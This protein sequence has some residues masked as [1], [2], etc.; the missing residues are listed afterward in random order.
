MFLYDCDLVASFVEIKIGSY[1][2]E[3]QAEETRQ[4]YTTLVFG[5]GLKIHAKHN[6]LN[7]R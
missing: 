5:W 4:T 2:R 1:V 7:P 6:L 3:L